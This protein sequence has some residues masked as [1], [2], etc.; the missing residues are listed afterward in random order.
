M[1]ND[2]LA[3]LYGTTGKSCGDGQGY[4][5]GCAKHAQA[6]LSR[7]RSEGCAA[8]VEKCMGSGAKEVVTEE[9]P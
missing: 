6:S 9:G 1:R 5:R 8:E 3:A 7:T 4:H 2:G